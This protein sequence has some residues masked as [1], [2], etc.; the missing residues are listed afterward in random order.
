M[1]LIEYFKLIYFYE[2]NK[3]TWRNILSTS[4]GILILLSFETYL[5]FSYMNDMHLLQ[6][7]IFKLF[8]MLPAILLTTTYWSSFRRGELY[9]LIT[10][11]PI[12][13]NTFIYAMNI[14]LLFNVSLKRMIYILLLPIYSVIMD[15]LY[16]TDG[17][18]KIVVYLLIIF[19]AQQ[20]CI[21]IHEQNNITSKLFLLILLL[22]T[23]TTNDYVSIFI[24]LLINLIYYYLIKNVQFS[25]VK[26]KVKN[27]RHPHKKNI[28]YSLLNLEFR[29]F[30]SDKAN[31]VSYLSMIV[32]LALITFN[33][34][35]MDHTV[36]DIKY[37]LLLLI[38]ISIS[39]L[40]LI[41]SSDKEYKN[42]L[43]YIP[44]NKARIFMTKLMFS[45]IMSQILLILCIIMNFFMFKDSVELRT[46][47][48][49]FIL[50]LC[51]FIR[52]KYDQ[53]FP[54]LEWENKNDLWKNPKKYMSLAIVIP[55]IYTF[56]HVHIVLTILFNVV[57][58]LTFDKVMSILKIKEKYFEFR[59][60]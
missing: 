42:L 40:N 37:F 44:I 13:N 4:I 1:R 27:K 47:N 41:F 30:F 39:P 43:V 57:V 51:N 12:K 38:I 56:I 29:K 24:L 3:F 23:S 50:F 16:L 9:N 20:I 59:T 46:L 60:H 28:T 48:L 55:Y 6:K 21:L 17:I 58:I 19:T 31:I 15:Q 36:F 35:K 7:N 14:H 53:Y 10:Y 33:F 22:F 54:I 5:V 18:T 34:S 25:K 26:V 32:F 49:L 2:R 52:M 8:I 45:S 11:L